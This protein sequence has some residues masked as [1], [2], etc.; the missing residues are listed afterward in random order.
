MTRCHVCGAAGPVTTVTRDR[1]P[2]MQNMV[3]RTREHALAAAEGAFALAACGSC[4]Y[5]WNAAFD[6]GR[7]T[8]D[9]SYDNAVPS[10][11]MA[12]YYVDDNA[13]PKHAYARSA[14]QISAS[15]DH[16]NKIR[17]RLC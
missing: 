14:L 10:A 3:H 5:A 8:Y 12:R 7:L 6:E 15:R 17:A 4:G 9:D 16:E 13:A 2:A 11:V 1:L